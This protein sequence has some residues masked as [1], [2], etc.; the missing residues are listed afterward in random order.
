[1]SKKSG[2]VKLVGLLS[3]IFGAVAIIGGITTWATVST[4]LAAENITVPADSP[5]VPGARVQDPISAYAQAEIINT[6]ALAS[7]G[8]RTFAQLG[9]EISAARTAGDTAKVEELTALRTT[10]MNA[11]FLRASLFTSVVAYGVALLVIGLGVM[12]ILLGWALGSLVKPAE[13]ASEAVEP[14]TT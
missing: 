3:I 2:P 7:S 5:L 14:A 8:G 1:M 6:H 12:F 10:M 13:A 11:S 4:Q 9:T